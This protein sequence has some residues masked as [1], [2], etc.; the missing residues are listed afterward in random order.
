MSVLYVDESGKSGLRDPVQPLHVLGGLA[1]SDSVWLANGTGPERTDRCAGAAAAADYWELH[2]TEMWNG[3][4]IFK[5]MPRSSRRAL[6]E[7]RPGRNDAHTR[8]LIFVVIDKA[9]LASK[10]RTPDSPDA[11]LSVHDR[12]V[13]QLS[14]AAW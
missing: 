2:M 1:V 4:G 8:T 9:A 7:G 13:R 5:P 10:Y 14:P 6:W 12:A 11:G 3:K